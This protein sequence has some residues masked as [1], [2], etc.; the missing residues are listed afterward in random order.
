MQQTLWPLCDAQLAG[1]TYLQD[2]PRHCMDEAGQADFEMERCQNHRTC[3]RVGVD[4]TRASGPK[5]APCTFL[6]F[7]EWPFPLKRG[8]LFSS[9]SDMVAQPDSEVRS[10]DKDSYETYDG[11]DV[12]YG[13]SFLSI[14]AAPVCPVCCCMIV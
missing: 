1:L 13:F 6:E 4:G 14:G 9:S 3:S 8:R 2:I 12:H 7:G 11:F 10:C 5:A